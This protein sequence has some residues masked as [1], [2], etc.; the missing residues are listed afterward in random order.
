[1]GESIMNEPIDVVSAIA[2]ALMLPALAAAIVRFLLWR[3]SLRPHA[4]PGREHERRGSRL[5]E[6]A[7]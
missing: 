5:S 4:D 3:D 6:R 7:T 1:M 2:L